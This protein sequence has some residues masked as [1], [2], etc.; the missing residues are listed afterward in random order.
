MESGAGKAW[1]SGWAS[2]LA[3][4]RSERV[5]ECVVELVEECVDGRVYGG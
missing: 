5:G 4:T 2:K 3:R 1:V